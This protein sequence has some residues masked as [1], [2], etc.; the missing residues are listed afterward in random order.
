MLLHKWGMVLV[1]D[2]SDKSLWNLFLL[3]SPVVL[4]VALL[5]KSVSFKIK[6]WLWLN[7]SMK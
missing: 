5:T 3:L 4:L 1:R 2:H 6:L 7:Y